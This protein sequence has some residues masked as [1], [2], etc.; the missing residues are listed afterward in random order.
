MEVATRAIEQERREEVFE[1]AAR[2]QIR[3]SSLFLVG[4]FISL[5]VNFLSQLLLVRYFATAEYGAVAYGLSIVAFCQPFASL[6][7]HDAA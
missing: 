6:G 5:G 3:G 1:D 7:L 4:R 2:T